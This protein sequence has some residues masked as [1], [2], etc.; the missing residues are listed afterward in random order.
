MRQFKEV[1]D[2]LGSLSAEARE[3][4]RLRWDLAELELRSDAR[5]IGRSA[6]VLAIAA[7]MALTALPVLAVS[8]AEMLDGLL[9]VSRTG[10]LLMTGLGLL[11]GG[12]AAACLVWLHFR[13]R[14]I[15]LEQTLEELREDALWVKAESGERKAES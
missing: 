2:E 13:R 15:G 9:G 8:V 14:F 10:W 12:S 1:K 4:L 5:L 3:M 7:L 6:V 11:A